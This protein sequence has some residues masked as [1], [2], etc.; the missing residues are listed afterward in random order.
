MQSSDLLQFSMLSFVV[1]YQT[2]EEQRQE[3][4]KAEMKTSS[5][6]LKVVAVELDELRLRCLLSSPKHTISTY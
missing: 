4:V 3:L 5:S 6:A 2:D 1:L